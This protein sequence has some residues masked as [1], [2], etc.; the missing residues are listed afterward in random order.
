MSEEDNTQKIALVIDNRVVEILNTDTFMKD[1]FLNHDRIVDVTS[2][3][4]SGQNTPESLIGMFHDQP[5]GVFKTAK[6]YPSWQ[7]DT[8]ISGWIPPVLMPNDDKDYIW[9]EEMQQWVEVSNS[10]T[11]LI[12]AENQ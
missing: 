4:N 1:I 2:L 9:L 7:W 5:T 8:T 10:G 12:Q 3:I 6:P 11:P